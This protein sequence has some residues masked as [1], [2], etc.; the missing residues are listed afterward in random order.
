VTEGATVHSRIVVGVDG[1][2]ASIRAL[3]WAVD[4]AALAGAAVEVINAWQDPGVPGGRVSAMGFNI[5]AT[6]D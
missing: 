1:S 6:A 3:K 4:Q 2:P 5:S